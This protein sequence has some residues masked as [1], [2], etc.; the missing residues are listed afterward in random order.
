MKKE[1][2]TMLAEIRNYIIGYYKSLDRNMQGASVV[3]TADVANVC[4]NIINSTDTLLKPYVKF[5]KN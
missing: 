2:I 3:K 5:E 1:E 4:E